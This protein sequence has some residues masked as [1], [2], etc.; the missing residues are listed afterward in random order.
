MT[1]SYLSKIILDFKLQDHEKFYPGVTIVLCIGLST[2]SPSLFI[3]NPNDMNNE[4][5]F[6]YLF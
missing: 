4:Y 1:E 5:F 3:S 6:F 2:L